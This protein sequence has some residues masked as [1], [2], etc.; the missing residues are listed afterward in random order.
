MEGAIHLINVSGSGGVPKL[1]VKAAMIG[2]EGLERL[3]QVQDGE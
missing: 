1:S 3:Q 2:F